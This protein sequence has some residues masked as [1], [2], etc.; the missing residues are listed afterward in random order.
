MGAASGSKEQLRAEQ[1]GAGEL[2][3][4]EGALDGLLGV[5]GEGAGASL[6]RARESWGA[7]SGSEEQ[8]R[9]KQGGVGRLEGVRGQWPPRSGGQGR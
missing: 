5:E 2:E 9:A 7:A 6:E 8:L 3:G 4:G 1:R